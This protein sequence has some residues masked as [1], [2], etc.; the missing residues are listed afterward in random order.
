MIPHELVA[1]TGLRQF[2]AALFG[3]WGRTADPLLLAALSLPLLCLLVGAV[4]LALT[5]ALGGT[6]E[7][8]RVLLR[9]DLGFAVLCAATVVLSPVA[10]FL[11][12]RALGRTWL[13]ARRPRREGPPDS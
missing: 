9:K 3:E 13:V 11:L 4:L 8:A 2:F 1:A 10:V 6:R 12:L 5:R 7:D